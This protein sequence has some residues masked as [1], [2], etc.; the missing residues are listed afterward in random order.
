MKKTKS[1][2]LVELCV[3][4]M[5]GI[6]LLVATTFIM[7]WVFKMQIYFKNRTYDNMSWVTANEYLKKTIHSAAYV[8]ISGSGAT[9]YLY[10]HGGNMANTFTNNGGSLQF[11]DNSGKGKIYGQE[12]RKN[13][14]VAATL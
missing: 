1:F 14:A 9:L 12:K 2:S 4:A 11:N 10:D 8:M 3:A 7:V 5:V 6:I 13:H